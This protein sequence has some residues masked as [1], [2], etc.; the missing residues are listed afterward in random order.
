[1]F[2]IILERHLYGMESCMLSSV[3]E[4]LLKILTEDENKLVF[5]NS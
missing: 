3:D 2:M 5:F 4:S 1:M